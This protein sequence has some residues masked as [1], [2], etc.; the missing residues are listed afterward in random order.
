MSKE[1]EEELIVLKLQKNYERE[2]SAIQ[3]KSKNLNEI[4]LKIGQRHHSRSTLK[5]NHVY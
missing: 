2:H 4:S 3:R 1:E 5:L